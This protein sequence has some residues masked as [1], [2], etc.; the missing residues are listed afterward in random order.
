MLWWLWLS[1]LRSRCSCTTYLA[2]G[3]CRT[4]SI[5][6]W[7]PTGVNCP[8]TDPT[9]LNTP[10]SVDNTSWRRTLSFPPTWDCVAPTVRRDMVLASVG[11]Q[12]VGR[13]SSGSCGAAEKVGG[14]FEFGVP[15][16]SADLV[17]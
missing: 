15:I 1:E 9:A 10:L 12:L 2:A 17:H 6:L 13:A 7:P 16:S 11:S 3:N 4:S 14:Y 8:V 5:P